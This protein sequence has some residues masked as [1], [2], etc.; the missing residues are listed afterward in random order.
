MA[1]KNGPKFSR[2]GNYCIVFQASICRGQN[3]VSFREVNILYV[4]ICGS[5]C[6]LTPTDEQGRCVDGSFCFN[7]DA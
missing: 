1:P 3:V 4:E 6:C 7:G 2:K 5:P